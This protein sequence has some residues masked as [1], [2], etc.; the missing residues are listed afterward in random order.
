LRFGHLASKLTAETFP[1]FTRKL[2]YHRTPLSLP[3]LWTE[4]LLKSAFRRWRKHARTKT[5]LRQHLRTSVERRQAR[6]K[7]LAFRWWRTH[8]R[9][10]SHIRETSAIAEEKGDRALQRWAL[11]RWAHA[12]R[13]VHVAVKK[14]RT[15][16]LQKGLQ[17]LF[18]HAQKERRLRSAAQAAIAR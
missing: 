3:G 14:W 6:L 17:G 18:G 12:V 13:M 16:W 15:S 8:A 1:R 11:A 5:T 7:S 10:R 9:F 2:L 4:G